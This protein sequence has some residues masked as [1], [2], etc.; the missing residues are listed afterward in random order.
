MWARAPGEGTRSQVWKVMLALVLVLGLGAAFVGVI[1]TGE[2]EAVRPPASPV[3]EGEDAGNLSAGFD[4]SQ[5]V[6]VLPPD[7]IPALTDPPFEAVS[8]VDWLTSEEPVIA[9]EQ[10]GDARAYPLQI[11]TWHEI[12]NNTVGGVPVAVTF[13]P[14]CNTA[15]A[16]H[17]P[18]VDGK[19]TTF[20][21]SG[22]LYHSNLL[23][24]DRA[25]DSLWPQALGVAATGKLKGTVLSRVPA[26]TVSWEEFRATF[27]EG[28][29]L[30]RDTGHTRNYGENPYPGYDDVDSQ[31]FLFQGEV[32]GRLAAVERVLGIEGKG[33]ITAFPYFR[34]EEAAEGGLVA[35]NAEVGRTPVM[36]VWK[37]GTRSALDAT[38]IAESKDVGAAFA[39]SR[40]LDQRVLSFDLVGGKIV[41]G[42]TG[43][44]WNIFG[45]AT[46]G[47]LEGKKLEPANAHDSFWFDWAAFHPN[48]QVWEG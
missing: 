31:P 46:S 43:S 11:M 30:T 40:R 21:T 23:M 26:Q 3:A 20:G 42:R 33:A 9:V 35:V 45:R 4:K 2:D 7:G 28:W 6:S 17:R 39:F 19:V 36:V 8:D 15:Y 48:T 22:K 13:C 41:D 1:L 24:Y 44:A 5:I 12:V 16:F 32:D 34:L 25:T 14:L 47:P 29:V 38:S 18:E 10:N 37:R 27:P